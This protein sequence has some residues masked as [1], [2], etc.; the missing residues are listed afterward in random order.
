MHETHE[1]VKVKLS[2]DDNLV[3]LEFINNEY[4]LL[5]NLETQQI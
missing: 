1:A 3:F 2:I 5:E 4:I